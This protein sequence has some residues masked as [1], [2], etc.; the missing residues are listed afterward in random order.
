MTSDK[1]SF[2]G[3]LEK[4]AKQK[5]AIGNGSPLHFWFADRPA[6]RLLALTCHL[7]LVTRHSSLISQSQGDEVMNVDDADR[8]VF[9]VANQ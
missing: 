4:V 6:D 8:A 3:C 1:I 7:L 2:R 5:W 9:P